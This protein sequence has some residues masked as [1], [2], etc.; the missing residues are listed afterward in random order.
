MHSKGGRCLI[1]VYMTPMQ[2]HIFQHVDF[3]D[4]GYILDWLSRQGHI[5]STTKFFDP[6][7]HLPAPH[8]IDGLIILGGPMGVYDE[9]EYPWLRPEKEYIKGILQLG[10]PL[11]G[12]CLGAQLLSVCLGG[13]V[14]PAPNKEIGWFPVRAVGESWLAA[15]FCE[16]P[17]VFHWHGDQFNIPPGAIPVAVSE[18]NDNQGFTY[19]ERIV[20]LQFHL[21][22]KPENLRRMVAHGAAELGHGGFVQGAEEI[23]QGEA[24]C[25]GMNGIMEKV[26][27]AV[28]G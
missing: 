14:V 5:I 25:R 23:L 17:T 27:G 13:S 18:A 21:E 28:F 7:Y 12:I 15:L 1:L 22:C 19:G 6:V 8:E 10:K 2:I 3:E 26:L 9:A 20:G 4:P 11:L 24:A 16:A